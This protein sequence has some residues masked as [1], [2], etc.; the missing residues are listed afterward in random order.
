MVSYSSSVS[1]IGS[2]SS[3]LLGQK[4]STCGAPQIRRH[5]GGLGMDT[6]PRFRYMPIIT[7]WA[8]K[9]NLLFKSHC[10]FRPHIDTD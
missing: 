3:H 8:E 1:R 7:L 2:V 5:R 10:N 9:S 6:P 4:V